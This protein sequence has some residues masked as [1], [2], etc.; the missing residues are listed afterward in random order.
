MKFISSKNFKTYWVENFSV[1]D[2]AGISNFIK[3]ET[4]NYLKNIKQKF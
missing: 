4:Q 2:H 1:E 3:Y